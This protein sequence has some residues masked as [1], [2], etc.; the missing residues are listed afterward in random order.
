MVKTT[1]D[2]DSD[3]DSDSSEFEE[4]KVEEGKI[5]VAWY[6]TNNRWNDDDEVKV[7]N[8]DT[9]S[10]YFNLA[11]NFLRLL[12]SLLIGHERLSKW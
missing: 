8:E 2:D 6:K 5:M 11:L 7:V 10:E 3:E 12:Y 1:R 9:V 4:D